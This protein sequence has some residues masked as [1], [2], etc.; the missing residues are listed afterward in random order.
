MYSG[1]SM[2]C[3]VYE[4]LYQISRSGDMMVVAVLRLCILLTNAIVC[5]RRKGE[6]VC[7]LNAF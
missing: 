1:T 4:H 3:F 7:F 6:K 5:Q 2:A